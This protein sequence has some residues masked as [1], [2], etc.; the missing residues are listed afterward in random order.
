MALHQSSQINGV[1]NR[2]YLVKRLHY[3]PQL[4][5][6]ISLTELDQYRSRRR[7]CNVVWD[8]DRHQHNLCLPRRHATS[9]SAPVPKPIR[10]YIQS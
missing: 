3:V 7:C 5:T 4:G 6:F 9:L 1:L 10:L 2:L 8:R